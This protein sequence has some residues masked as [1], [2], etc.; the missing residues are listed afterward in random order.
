MKKSIKTLLIG[1]LTMVSAVLL[2]LCFNWGFGATNYSAKANYRA[3]FA[4]EG[5]SG[6]TESVLFSNLGYAYSTD[7]KYLLLVTAFKLDEKMQERTDL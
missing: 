2:T 4:S 6:A 3:A 5:T 7:G 1:S